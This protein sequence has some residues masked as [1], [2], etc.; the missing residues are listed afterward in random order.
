MGR[1]GP[2]WGLAVKPLLTPELGSEIRKAGLWEGSWVCS[3]GV[4][5]LGRTWQEA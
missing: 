5:G 3:K 4:A 1:E 2:G